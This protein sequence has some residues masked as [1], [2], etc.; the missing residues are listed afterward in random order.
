LPAAFS[1]QVWVCFPTVRIV[2]DILG[3]AHP[4]WG[5]GSVIGVFFIIPITLVACF[6]AAIPPLVVAISAAHG[7][8]PDPSLQDIFSVHETRTNSVSLATNV[9]S[10]KCAGYSRMG[11]RSCITSA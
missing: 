7:P 4:Y 5:E 9:P 11:P 3:E 1:V 6:A 2:D 8:P 10:G